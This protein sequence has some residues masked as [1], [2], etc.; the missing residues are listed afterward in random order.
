MF[1]DLTEQEKEALAKALNESIQNVQYLAATYII[2]LEIIES[3][4]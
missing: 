3:L 4:N 2:P 1:E